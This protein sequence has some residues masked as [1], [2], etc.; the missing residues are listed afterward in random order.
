MS[1]LAA[2]SNADESRRPRPLVTIVGLR[3]QGS[4][5]EDL[6]F[7]LPVPDHWME[8]TID[9]L[10]PELKNM[11]GGICTWRHCTQRPT[12]LE[13]IRPCCHRQGFSAYSWITTKDEPQHDT[14]RVKVVSGSQSSCYSIE[15]GPELRISA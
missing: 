4:T 12:M 11:V 7:S 2:A 6:T 8:K 14:V 3:R 13:L 15:A 5:T 10:A 1:D 9:D